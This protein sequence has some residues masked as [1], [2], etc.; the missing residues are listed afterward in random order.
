MRRIGIAYLL[1]P[2]L[3]ISGVAAYYFG[4]TKWLD[5][6]TVGAHRDELLAWVEQ[7]PVLAALIFAAGYA[8]VVALSLP[9]AAVLTLLAGF[10]FG[11]WLGTAL[12]VTAA[13]LGAVGIFWIAKTS[14]GETLRE[15]AGPLYNRIAQNM[16]EGAVGY[17]LFLR[18]V[19]V[20]P[21]FLVNIVSA[22]FQI[23]TISFAA[24]T[25]IGII[26]GTF[27]YANLGREL[28]TITTLHDLVSAQ[29]LIAFS[30][31]G[32]ISLLP[33]VYRKW[34]AKRAALPSAISP[35]R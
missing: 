31:L 25:F 11:R 4:L 34:N 10:L 1:V 30:L 14:L 12:V 8:A 5:L 28:G 29:T 15:R 27:V 18:L 35:P 6:E 32:L 9:A 17:L 13:T 16:Q 20:F 22:L 24:A 7:A 2:A 21:F 26:P 3:L 23:D 19:P 33:T